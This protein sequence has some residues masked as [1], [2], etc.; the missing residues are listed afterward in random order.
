MEEISKGIVAKLFISQIAH[1][2]NRSPSTITREVNRYGGI[3]K[4]RA[5]KADSR[6]WED[7]KRPKLCKLKENPHLVPPL[8]KKLGLKWSPEQ[9]SCGLKK[10][11]PKVESY[12]V[13]HEMIYKSLFIQARG[14][15][16]KELQLLL[17]SKR[18]I[19]RARTS[20]LKGEGL[21]GI[22][23]AVSILERPVS[24]EDRALLGHW[25]GDLIQGK[26]LRFYSDVSRA[27]H[28]LFNT[29]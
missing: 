4:Y 27:S 1:N 29:R 8:E 10:A 18:L 14:A 28:S 15:L 3:K 24:L 17:R 13:L 20:S 25:E 11:F 26:K 16:K 12:Q 9:I 23:N 5:A 2:L 21:G 6:A 7:A 22:P 19:R